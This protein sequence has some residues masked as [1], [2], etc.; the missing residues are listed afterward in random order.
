MGPG[1][2]VQSRRVR[3]TTKPQPGISVGNRRTAGRNTAGSE[4][5]TTRR[6]NKYSVIILERMRQ[7]GW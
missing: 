4:E 2:L 3:Y 1:I 5:A 6:M 7:M